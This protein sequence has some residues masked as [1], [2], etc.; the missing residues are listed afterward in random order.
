MLQ[1]LGIESRLQLA[2][3]LCVA[4]LIIVTTLGTSGG[5][6]VVFFIYRT[7]LISIAILCTIG[8]DR[9]STRLNSS[10]PSISYAVFC[11]KKK[12]LCSSQRLRKNIFCHLRQCDSLPP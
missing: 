3:T 6:P 5:A 7:L 1:Q 9:K 8:S 4:A 11:L 2:I 10:H 12:T